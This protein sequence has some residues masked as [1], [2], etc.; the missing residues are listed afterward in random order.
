ML[1]A[2]DKE[3]RKRAGIMVYAL[4]IVLIIV[5]VDLVI[6]NSM[7]QVTSQELQ[8]NNLPESFR[9]FKILHITDLHSKS[10]GNKNEVL[11]KAIN[12]QE[13][14]LVVM[15]G[16]MVNSR[17]NDFTVLFDLC[18][19]IAGNYPIYWV[20]GNHEQGLDQQYLEQIMG[21]LK[22]KDIPVLKNTAVR[23]TRG[24]D[25]I[26]LWGLEM[27][28]RYYSR[29]INGQRDYRFGAKQINELL[30]NVDEQE[31]NIL[32]THN[33]VY[34]KTY[35]NW[36]ADLTLCGHMHGGM[37]RIPFLGGLLSPEVSFFPKYDAGLF[38]EDGRYMYVSRG[39]GNGVFPVRLFNRP[40]IAV[41]TLR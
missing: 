16:D 20:N 3:M 38:V 4:L 36:G 30:P 33:P 2:A 11:I 9:G 6:S 28:M 31:L 35:A 14:D 12:R 24:Q 7:I 15:T 13:P 1:E 32:L 8:F 39:V 23:I 27:A 18:D 10:F 37:I 19:R 25:Y 41:I 5:V 17:D 29:S 34:F 21:Y 22:A 26:N 40:E